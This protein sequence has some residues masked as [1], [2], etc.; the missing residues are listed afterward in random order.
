MDWEFIEDLFE[1]HADSVIH[2]QMSPFVWRIN[3]CQDGR[4]DVN[5]SDSELCNGVSAF[6]TL[7]LAKSFCESSENTSLSL[8][9]VHSWKRS[10][11]GGTYVCDCGAWQ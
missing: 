8:S 7:S 9:H 11:D 1:W 4:F 6:E 5:G 2:D 10:I 3:V